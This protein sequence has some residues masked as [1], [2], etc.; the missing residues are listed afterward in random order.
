MVPSSYSETRPSGT[1][2]DAVLSKRNDPN[3]S[4]EKQRRKSP[5]FVAGTE[6]CGGNGSLRK[7][8]DLNSGLSIEAV[9][10]ISEN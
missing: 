2:K 9:K 7:F 4:D 10:K 6:H 3:F 8:Q 1:D 5:R